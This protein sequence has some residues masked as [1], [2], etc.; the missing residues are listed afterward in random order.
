[1]EQLGGQLQNSFFLE[2]IVSLSDC[3]SAK[4]PLR[5][6][7]KPHVI[8]AA[9]S[10]PGAFTIGWMLCILRSKKLWLSNGDKQLFLES[11][12]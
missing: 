12:T 2:W 3:E 1:M 4:Q 6:I 8:V 5:L 7:S 11:D 10:H 9:F